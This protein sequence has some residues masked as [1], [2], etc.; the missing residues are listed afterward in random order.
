MSFP[1]A[2]EGI[3]GVLI[4]LPNVMPARLVLQKNKA[5]PFQSACLSI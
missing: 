4:F 3:S 5:R 1:K 2:T